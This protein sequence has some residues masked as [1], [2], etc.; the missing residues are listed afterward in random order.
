VAFTVLTAQITLSP[1]ARNDAWASFDGGARTHL[2]KDD[3]LTV[4]TSAFPFPVICADHPV[5]DW[6]DSLA[7]C[8]HW[9]VRKLQKPLSS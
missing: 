9:N 5:T 7:Q 6:F 3:R 2:R 4:T 1:N 8:L